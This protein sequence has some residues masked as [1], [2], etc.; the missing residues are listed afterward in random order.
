MTNL[1]DY[2]TGIGTLSYG[3]FIFPPARQYRIVEKP[4]YDRAERAVSYVDCTLEVL[5][6][7]SFSDEAS[8]AAAVEQAREY[9]T[10]PGQTLT[11]DNIGLG[12]LPV[13]GSAVIDLNWGPKP[14]LVSCRPAGGLLSW[15]IQWTCEFRISHCVTSIGGV[16]LTAYNY[17]VAYSI[18]EQGLTTR[19]IAGYAEI[20]QTRSAGGGSGVTKN[21]DQIWEQIRVVV[22][23]GFRRVRSDHAISESKNRLEFVII[24]QELTAEAFPPGIVD[25]DIDYEI[26][27]V[28]PGFS[29]FTA[30]ISGTLTVAKGY[31]YALAAQKFFLILSDR[32]QKLRT[33]VGGAL[34]EAAVIPTRIRFG[35]GMFSRSSRFLVEFTIV[36]CLEDLLNDGGVWE[37]L[38]SNAGGD[39]P[40]W[41]ASMAQVWHPRGIAKLF[42][43]PGSDTIISLCDGVSI[44]AIDDQSQTDNALTGSTGLLFGCQVNEGNS[45]LAFENKVTYLKRETWSKHKLAQAFEVAPPTPTDAFASTGASIGNYGTGPAARSDIIQTT[46]SSEEM[47]LMQGKSLRL[48]YEPAIPTLETVGGVTVREYKRIVEVVPAGNFFGCKLYRARWAILYMIT[49]PVAGGQKLVPAKN[50]LVCQND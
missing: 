34:N 15:E 20:G 35:R 25:G 18:D 32:L 12:G 46:G 5:C 42:H 7:I 13:D 8:E 11:V 40:A 37:P 27:N 4:V 38:G 39:Y 47:F 45:Y 1:V 24:D 50:K 23:N 10:R 21:A 28:P 17:R 16:N 31:P 30:Q 44:P 41:A 2:T 22:P 29:R 6:W 48:K 26:G 19:Q 14:R 43:S 49:T 33:A 9:L 36:G 3:S